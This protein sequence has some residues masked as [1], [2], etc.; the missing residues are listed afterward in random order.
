MRYKIVDR[1]GVESEE[2]VFDSVGVTAMT[3][4]TPTPSSTPTKRN[5]VREAIAIVSVLV[6]LNL[7]LFGSLG[8]LVYIGGYNSLLSPSLLA[9]SFGIRHAVDADH[10]AAID[11]VTRKL[12]RDGRKP[13]TVKSLS[14]FIFLVSYYR[15]L[16]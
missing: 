1:S 5:V 6:L 13:L 7:G 12:I 2:E 15:L 8:A 3:Q 16:P 11:N 14:S 9:F 10:I 4:G